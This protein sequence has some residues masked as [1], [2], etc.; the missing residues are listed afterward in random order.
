MTSAGSSGD[1]LGTKQACHVLYFHYFIVTLG[2]GDTMN[3]F[4]QLRN[5]W[6]EGE[7]DFPVI[8]KFASE[9]GLK[10]RP[11]TNTWTFNH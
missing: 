8:T 11:D 9:P 5:L 1:P 7:C 4:S 10:I 3:S 2:D 6:V